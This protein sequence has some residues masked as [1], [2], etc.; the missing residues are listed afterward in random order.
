MIFRSFLVKNHPFFTKKFIKPSKCATL[1]TPHPEP[2]N[3]GEKMRRLLY[4]IAVS[5]FLLG[6][7]AFSA[8]KVIVYGENAYIP[9]AFLNG[10]DP[11]GIYVKILQKAF[12]RMD[13]Y[14]VTIKLVPWKR[15]MKF[16]ESGEAF[17]A[18]APYYR[19]EKRPWIDPYSEPIIKEGFAV[20]CRKDVLSTPRPNWPG[21]YENLEIGINLGYAVPDIE[22]LHIQESI[23]NETNITKM[24]F[25]RIDC[26]VNDDAAI[27]YTLKKM[28]IPSGTFVKGTQISNENGYLAFSKQNKAPYRDD[29]VVK[30]N[31]VLMEM[32]KSGE[33]DM[34][35]SEFLGN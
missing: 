2:C 33:I 19:P 15:A 11:D 10:T 29:F 4:C 34:I 16:V 26:Y 27:R 30:F 6:Q 21:D 17:A 23:D 25:R 35:V 31:K 1:K 7:P 20:Y 22:S 32:K 5:V 9:Y 14:D 3:A 24:V 12:A 28:R 13:G 18:F 8:R